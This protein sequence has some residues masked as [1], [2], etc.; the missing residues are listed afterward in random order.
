MHFDPKRAER[1]PCDASLERR[2]ERDVRDVARTKEQ[3]ENNFAEIRMEVYMF[4][5]FVLSYLLRWIVHVRA[6]P[7]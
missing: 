2:L 5:M 6:F 3:I 7:F 1:P 4:S